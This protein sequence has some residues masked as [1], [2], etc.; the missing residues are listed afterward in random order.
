MGTVVVGDA[1]ALSE[2]PFAV[3]HRALA[4]VEKSAD[5][6]LDAGRLPTVD[7]GESGGAEADPG[8]DEGEHDLGLESDE[9]L[10]EI[11][12]LVVERGPVLRI[13]PFGVVENPVDDPDAGVSEGGHA[14]ERGGLLAADLTG[15]LEV[16]HRSASLLPGCLGV[17]DSNL[18]LGLGLIDP[19]RPLD[20]G[21]LETDVR[22]GDLERGLDGLERLLRDVELALGDS[23]IRFENVGLV[24]RDVWEV[25]RTKV[26]VVELG[27]VG[28][29]AVGE[30]D[31]A[32]GASGDW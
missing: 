7:P 27:A 4:V 18:D 12:G 23:G 22:V 8:K 17:L 13:K 32:H 26:R 21:G 30:V 1:L 24:L 3:A 29:G 16:D 14:G 19:P 6:V 15:L 25:G 31:L 20:P 10:C 28:E 11:D 2:E 9:G 5:L